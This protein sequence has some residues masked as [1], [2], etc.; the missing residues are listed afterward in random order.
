MKALVCHGLG[1]RKLDDR[2][3]P[4]VQEPTTPMLLRT[5]QPGKLDPRQLITH[6][7]T[8]NEIMKAYDTF[9]NAAQEKALKVILTN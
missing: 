8:L 7:F 4:T 3:K 2:P 5:V 9:A 1:M 6:H